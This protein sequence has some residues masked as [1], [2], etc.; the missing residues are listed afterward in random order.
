MCNLQ[1][2]T[3]GSAALWSAV[4]QDIPGGKIKVI[5]IFFGRYGATYCFH[6]LVPYSVFCDINTQTPVFE[7]K[8]LRVIFSPKGGKK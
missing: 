6:N 4:V 7:K 8:M 5:N 1:R 3:G 2:C